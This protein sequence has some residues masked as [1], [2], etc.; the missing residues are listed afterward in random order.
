MTRFAR[1]L[2][3]LNRTAG[4]GAVADQLSASEWAELRDEAEDASTALLADAVRFKPGKPIGPSADPMDATPN[5]QTDPRAAD[6]A[7]IEKQAM[8]LYE[9]IQAGLGALRVSA[10]VTSAKN[11]V[12]FGFG[13]MTLPFDRAAITLIRPGGKTPHELLFASQ[14]EVAALRK[15]IEDADLRPDS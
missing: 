13:G 5:F 11:Y 6:D 8:L 7:P 10:D 3:L 2:E 15:T 9:C 4:P 14:A 1:L 12:E